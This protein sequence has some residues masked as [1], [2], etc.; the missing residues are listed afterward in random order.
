MQK[1]CQNKKRCLEKE[2]TWPAAGQRS[3]FI[4]SIA[5]MAIHLICT[6]HKVQ[7]VS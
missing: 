1:R 2:F 6:W 7:I 3:I 4:A 5:E